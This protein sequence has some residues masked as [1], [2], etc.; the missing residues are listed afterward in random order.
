MFSSSAAPF[1]SGR[2]YTKFVGHALRAHDGDFGAA[3]RAVSTQ[4]VYIPHSPAES[5]TRSPESDTVAHVAIV[6]LGRA[7]AERIALL[8]GP[9]GSGRGR[10][11][12]VA[13]IRMRL[14]STRAPVSI[15]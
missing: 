13:F 4:G 8:D 7:P 1:E 3:A 15:E 5:D 6:H 10:C 11:H 14:V 2:S 9:P 12:F